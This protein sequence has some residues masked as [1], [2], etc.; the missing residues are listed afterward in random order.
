AFLSPAILSLPED[1]ISAFCKE[2]PEKAKLYQHFLENLLRQKS[3]SLSAAE[4]KLLAQA[5]ELG[6]AHQ[7][8]F[9]MLNEADLT[10][11]AILDEAGNV[12]ELTKGRYISYL[13]SNDRTLRASAFHALYDAYGR[14]KNTLAAIYSASVKSDVF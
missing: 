1:T 4:E 5:G 10:F 2:F 8:I 12:H 9:T 7:Q 13:E 6:G 14:Q 11:P 3:H